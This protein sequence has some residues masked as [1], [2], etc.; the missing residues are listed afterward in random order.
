MFNQNV[1][2][3]K[4]FNNS[5]QLTHCYVFIFVIYLSKKS[6]LSRYVASFSIT[7]TTESVINLIIINIYIIFIRFNKKI[8]TNFH[9]DCRGYL[10]FYL[11]CLTIG[12]RHKSKDFHQATNN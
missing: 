1:L 7:K 2:S 11:Y 9:L 5:A 12:D 10:R 3:T 4:S 8:L 6:K